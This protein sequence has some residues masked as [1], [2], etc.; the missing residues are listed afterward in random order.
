MIDA[1]KDGVVRALN[2]SENG[3]TV[4]QLR[5]KV[6]GITTHDPAIMELVEEGK[7]KMQRERL[8]PNRSSVVYSLTAPDQ[9]T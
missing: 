7:V 1:R 5:R 6:T 3:M 8:H 2:S 4:T 9:I